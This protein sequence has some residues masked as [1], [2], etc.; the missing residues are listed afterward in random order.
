MLGKPRVLAL[1]LVVSLACVAMAVFIVLD[2]LDLDGSNFSRGA[3]ENTLAADPRTPETERQLSFGG[4]PL[5]TPT[6]ERL[7]IH[8]SPLLELVDAQSTFS[9]TPD[10]PA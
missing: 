3:S 9:P 8:P 1:R 5:S 4:G 6:T 10:D 2:V 7:S